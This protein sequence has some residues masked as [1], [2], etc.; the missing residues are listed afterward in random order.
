MWEQTR[1][2]TL[3]LCERSHDPLTSRQRIVTVKISKDTAQA[4]KEAQK[5]LQSKLDEYKPKRLHLSDLIDRYEKEL[6]RTV[7]D[8]TYA[9]NCCSL[10][11]M[12]K[13]LDDVYIDKM[14]AGYIRMKLIET[15]KSNGYMNELIKRFKAM[16]IWAYKND[17]LDREVADKLDK[18]QI[19]QPEKRLRISSWRRKSFRHS[20]ELL[21]WKDGRS[22]PNSLPCL[23]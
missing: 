23:D 18:F 6:E 10:N 7:R 3:Y 5:R 21:T 17:Y 8:S 20:S 16:L 12:L 4:R 15:G 9:R 13:I 14:T 19:V 1:N 22:S 11:T 2:N